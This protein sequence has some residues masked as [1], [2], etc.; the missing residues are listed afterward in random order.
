MQQHEE[1]IEKVRAVQ[2]VR[3]STEHQQYSTANQDDVI[4]E[5][6]DK[7]NFEIVKTYADEGLSLIHI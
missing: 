5:Y 3:M 1:P 7:R 4:Q 6:A 2:Y